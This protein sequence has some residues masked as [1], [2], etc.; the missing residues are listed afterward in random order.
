MAGLLCAAPAARSL[1]RPAAA[2]RSR[3]MNLKSTRSTV[4]DQAAV[5]KEADLKSTYCFCAR[6][7]KPRYL[8]RKTLLYACAPKCR[9]KFA[10]HL[11]TFELR[12]LAQNSTPILTRTCM[13]WNKFIPTENQLHPVHEKFTMKLTEIYH[14]MATHDSH[15]KFWTCDS[16][17]TAFQLMS[18]VTF[19]AQKTIPC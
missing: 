4:I 19:F 1:A 16:E 13:N 12:E 14:Y 10:G 18:H 6:R 7:V 11:Q 17:L 2:R 5:A 9:E 8:S 3:R 15:S